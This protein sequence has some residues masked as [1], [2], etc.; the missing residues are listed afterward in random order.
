MN[1]KLIIDIRTRQKGLNFLLYTV[2]SNSLSFFTL[3][4]KMNI[5]RNLKLGNSRSKLCT[6]TLYSELSCV[7]V[8]YV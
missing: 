6:V 8:E 2:Y 7:R 1:E 5:K 3:N 4:S